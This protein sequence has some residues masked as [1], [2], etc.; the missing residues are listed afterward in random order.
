MVFVII[1]IWYFNSLGRKKKYSLAAIL[2][3]NS[4]PVKI[5]LAD[6]SE[7]SISQGIEFLRLGTIQLVSTYEERSIIGNMISDGIFFHNNVIPY[8]LILHHSET[9]IFTN[10]QATYISRQQVCTPP[11]ALKFVR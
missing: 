1:T 10:S 6:N 9:F 3:N 4:L 7:R 5:D 11:V 8:R 2:E